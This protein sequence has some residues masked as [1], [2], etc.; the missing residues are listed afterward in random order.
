MNFIKDQKKFNKI[1]EMAKNGDEKAKDFLF[2]FMEMDEDEANAFLSQIA[3]DEEGSEKEFK[4]IIEALIKDENEAI[5]GY[6]RAIKYLVNS[7]IEEKEKKIEILTH[8]KDEELEHIEELKE[9]LE[10]GLE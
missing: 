3:V 10:D 9:V 7:N 6:D 1:K 4:D 8:I 2:S 5:D